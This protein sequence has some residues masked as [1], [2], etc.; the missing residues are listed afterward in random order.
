MWRIRAISAS[1][2]GVD[3]DT[4]SDVRDKRTNLIDELLQIVTSRPADEVRIQVHISFPQSINDYRQLPFLS[5]CT[6]SSQQLI[7]PFG[8]TYYLVTTKF[9][10]TP[11]TQSPISS[12]KKSISSTP[13]K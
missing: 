9:Q 13:Q 8:V 1:E 3:E 2:D 6:L 12:K 7:N 10:Q 11:K 4:L 5:T